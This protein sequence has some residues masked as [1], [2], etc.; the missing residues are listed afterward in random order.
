MSTL[1][2]PATLRVTAASPVIALLVL[3]VRCPMVPLTVRTTIKLPVT[4]AATVAVGGAA[5]AAGTLAV[6]AGGGG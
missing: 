3:T 6:P 5:G 2:A 1:G 4:V